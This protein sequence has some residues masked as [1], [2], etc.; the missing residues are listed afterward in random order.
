MTIP[1]YSKGSPLSTLGLAH[2]HQKWGWED[3][4]KVVSDI[5]VWGLPQRHK[6]QDP[7]WTG[8][9]LLAQLTRFSETWTAP[10]ETKPAALFPGRRWMVSGNLFPTAPPPPPGFLIVQLIFCFPVSV[11]L[12]PFSANLRSSDTKGVDGPTKWSKEAHEAL[13]L[14]PH[15]MPCCPC[16]SQG[17]VWSINGD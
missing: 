6:T 13:A 16:L 10:S 5:L 12:F 8:S 3:S 1:T 9:K 15:Q 14:C 17:G 2:H 4:T 11:C 7:H